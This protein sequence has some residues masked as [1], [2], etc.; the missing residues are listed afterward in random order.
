MALF[1]SFALVTFGNVLPFY[2]FENGTLVPSLA[3]N[4]LLRVLTLVL[5]GTGEASF[6]LLFYLF[7]SGRFAPRWARWCALVVVTYWLAVVFF[8]TLPSSA[9]GPATY[10][11][12]L[13]LLS[14]VVAQVYRYRRI[15]TRGERQQTKWAVFG[16]ALAILLILFSIPLGFLVPPSIQND[17]ILGNLNPIFTLTLPLIPL[18]LAIAVMRS[19]LWDID[20]LINKALVYGLLTGLLA[21]LYAGLIIGLESLVG[22]FGGRAASNVLA[23]VISTLVI[24]ALFQ[25]LRSR[26]QRLIDRRFY[27]NKYDAVRTLEAFSVILRNE[28]D[29][30][31]LTEHLLTI[32]Q[33]TTQPASVSL[34]L[35]EPQKRAAAISPE[36]RSPSDMDRL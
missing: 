5:F 36:F 26:I 24:Y 34:W 27:R 9:G 2:N 7:P 25:P 20:T 18:F 35:D 1:C 3:S 11:I 17:P 19:R 32:I 33:E 6:T 13:S 21:A 28:V 30:E 8:P 31:Q 29:L 16:F 4:V 14:A 15:S 23:L 10:F 22:L 12:P